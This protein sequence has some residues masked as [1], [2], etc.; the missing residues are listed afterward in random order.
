MDYS[1]KVCTIVDNGLFVELAATLSKSFG[2][3]NY[4]S[5]WQAGF[6]KSNQ[7]LIGKGIPGVNRVDGVFDTIKDTDLF[8]FP[9][10][11]WGDFQVY[12][13]GI[14][15]K[16]WGSMRGEE[17]E[18][19]RDE[20]K[21]HLKQLGLS[22]GKYEVVV[23]LDAL[24][25]Y[26]KKND[27]QWVKISMTR[28]DMESFH[29]ENYEL[30]EPRLDELEHNL[31]AKKSITKFIVEE[32]IERA[33]EIAYDGYT[34]DG[35]FPKSATWGIEI[36]DKAYLGVFCPYSVMPKQIRDVNT[37]LVS[38]LKAYRYRNF[39]SPEMRIPMATKVPFVIDPCMRFG[40]PPSEIQ[41]LMFKNLADILWGGAEGNCIEPKPAGKF[42]AE[43]LIHSLWA[44]KNWQVVQFPPEIKDN[45]KLRN[46]TMIDGEHYVV[47]QSVGLPEIG[48]VVAIGDTVNEAIA[49]VKQYAKKIEGY[50]IDIFPD[51]LNEAGTEIKKLNLIGIEF[52]R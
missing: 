11:Y 13:K 43:L 44:D 24:R 42:G 15:K 52:G 33:V 45:V 23:G 7:M 10:V 6:V 19:H 17:L 51:S 29:S 26:L 21:K 4:F 14:G 1:S 34:I 46:L 31:G 41:L 39:F 28:G 48:A 36:K 38:T 2:K 25:S 32:N 18:L 47:P 5:P 20:S 50:Y 35:D 9:D 27:N 16:V 40:S 37:A 3:V 30:I 22:I 12:L 49:R 8:V